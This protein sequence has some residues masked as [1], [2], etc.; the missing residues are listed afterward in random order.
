MVGQC[1][2]CELNSSWSHPRAASAL[3]RVSVPP[4]SS[5]RPP[6]VLRSPNDQF[7]F[8]FFVLNLYLFIYFNWRLITLQYCGCFCHTS[9]LISIRYTYVPSFLNH[10]TP[11]PPPPPSRSY[12]SRLSQSF[13]FLCH[14]SNSH[15]LSI[16]H[17]VMCMFQCYFP[18]SS[19]PLLPTLCS[20][21]LCLLCCPAAM[22][23]EDV[24]SLE[25]KL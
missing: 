19:H 5:S 8:F 17:M 7:F 11:P 13:G 22:K 1:A 14:T 3:L 16:L 6:Q 2:L 23:L 21:C 25:G 10:P 9:T 12:S 20:K 4:F 18:K 15:W 24:Y